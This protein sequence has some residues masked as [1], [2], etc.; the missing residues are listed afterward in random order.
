VLQK[1]L[2]VS[3]FCCY[4][5]IS[6]DKIIF[7]Q[8]DTLVCYASLLYRARCQLEVLSYLQLV[9]IINTI[10]GYYTSWKVW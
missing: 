8:I 3:K 2:S 9:I 1:A 4:L 6:F 5:C 10:Q 7:Q